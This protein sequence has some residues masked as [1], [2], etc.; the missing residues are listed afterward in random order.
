MRR[1]DLGCGIKPRKGWLNLDWNIPTF[2]VNETSAT[3]SWEAPNEIPFPENSIDFVYTSHF[4]EHLH[5]QDAVS[6]L[7]E[8]F[9]VLKPEG[10]LSIVLPNAGELIRAYTNNDSKTLEKYNTRD[11]QVMTTPASY[12][13][14]F[15][16]PDRKK[17][18]S[19]LLDIC[20]LYKPLHTLG[21]NI[22]EISNVKRRETKP[23]NPLLLSNI[24]LITDLLHSSGHMQLYDL[25]KIIKQCTFTGFQFSKERKFIEGLDHQ[26][27]DSISFYVDFI[28]P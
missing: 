1:V 11:V 7:S 21:K 14:D 19:D 4:L 9:R 12:K 25:D 22:L 6:T 16:Y 18:I 26:E 15:N 10:I 24:D 8:C 20:D 17:E 3:I 2:I 28:K 5:H 27:N 23:I 13:P